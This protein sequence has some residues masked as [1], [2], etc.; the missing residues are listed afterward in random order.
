MEALFWFLMIFIV[1]FTIFYIIP[2][3]VDDAWKERE[4]TKTRRALADSD[5]HLCIHVGKLKSINGVLEN[6]LVKS[7]NTYGYEAG[8]LR[9]EITLTY[10]QPEIRKSNNE[11]LLLSFYAEKAST[12]SI[13]VVTSNPETD[14]SVFYSCPITSDNYNFKRAYYFIVKDI[15]S[16]KESVDR[17]K[18]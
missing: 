8:L 15:S 1:M 7:E 2:R 13:N 10:T 16:L 9:I 11:T 6:E 3:F 14:S 5:V 12:Y 18:P 4:K 17:R